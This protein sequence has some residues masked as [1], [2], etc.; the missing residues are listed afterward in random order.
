MKGMTSKEKKADIS[1]E[2]RVYQLQK[3]LSYFFAS[4][5]LFNYP[6]IDYFSFEISES[7]NLLLLF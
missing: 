6:S 5:K 4:S 2:L 1:Q 7:Y 3:T